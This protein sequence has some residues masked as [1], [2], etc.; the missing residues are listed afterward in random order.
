MGLESTLIALESPPQRTTRSILHQW[1]ARTL[2]LAPHCDD[3]VF[4][5]GLIVRLIE[6]RCHVD[7]AVAV[8]DDVRS[9]TAGRIIRADERLGELRVSTAILGL[10]PD[11]VHVGFAAPEI[12]LDRLPQRTIVTWLDDLLEATRPTALLL[13][14]PSHHVDHRVIHQ[15]ARSALRHDPGGTVRFAALWE[16]PYI[17]TDPWDCDVQQRGRITFD[18]TG[19]PIEAK[20]RAMRAHRS[21]LAGKPDRH[22]ISPEGIEKL[23][24][25][26]GLEIGRDYGESYYL[27]QCAI[28]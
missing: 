1:F 21:Q 11:Q 3:E 22:L 5:G 18:I 13:P 20:L 12:R 15:A 23:A 27:I 19:R 17:L 6:D 25:L 7:V 26:R 28:L 16:Y 4:C 8:A 9:R 24:M 2:V 14:Y 10:K